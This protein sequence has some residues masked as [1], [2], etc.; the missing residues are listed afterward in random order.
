MENENFYKLALRCA[1]R[2]IASGDFLNFYKELY[3]EKFSAKME[4]ED[5]PNGSKVLEVSNLLASECVRL[6]S[7]EKSLIL[8]NYVVEMVFVNYNSDLVHAFLPQ[9]YYIT[10]SEMLIHFFAQSS[11]F[12]SKLSDKLVMDQLNKY[13]SAYVIPS[14]LNVDATTIGNDLVVAICKFLLLMM[15]F[16]SGNVVLPSDMS[17]DNLHALLSRLSK[18]NKL[19]HKKVQQQADAKLVFKNEK[20]AIF[21][22]ESTVQ[23]FVSSPSIT[24]PQFEP[25][26][27]TNAKT[28]A[29]R[30]A[31]VSGAKYQDVKL[32][33]YYKNIWLNNKIINWAPVNSDFLTRYAS[34]ATSAFQ[35]VTY[36][37]RSTDS[38]LQ[39]LIET[40]FTCFAQFVNNKQYHQINS[41][42]NLLERQWMIFICKHLPLLI[43]ENGSGNSH[44]VP[45]ALESIDDKVVKAIRTY[46]S[47]KDDM[48]GRNE[49]L[50]DDYPSNNLDIRHE[51]I[52]N[53]VSL[54]LQSPTL[55]NDYLR[56]DQMIDTRTLMA[57]DDLIVKNSQGVQEL[58]KDIKHFL[59]SSLDAL[60]PEVLL[61]DSNDNA[62][63]LQQ[64]FQN[65]ENIPPTK[66]RNISNLLVEI[67]QHALENLE[68]DRIAK[69]C[70]VLS[71]NFSHSLTSILS[72]SSPTKICEM[73]IKFVDVSWDKFVEP[74]CKELVES[75]Y[76]TMNFFLS[77][78]CSI[79]LLIVI[80]QT[81]DF[82]LVD[83]VLN[84]P[85]SST[86]NSFVISYL[87]KLPEI[88]DTFLLDPKNSSDQDM[89]ARSHQVVQNWLRDLFVNGS[90]SD[91]LLQSVDLKQLAVL[92]P[93]IFKQ[94]LLTLEVG[95]IEDVSNLV[96]GLEY[97]L[98][99][100]M[101][102]GLIKIVY[103]LEQ[104]LYSL[105]SE[106]LDENLLEKLL[107]LLNSIF[108]PQALNEDSKLF[109]SALLRLNAVRLLRVLR[110]FRSQS[111][112]SYGIYSSEPSGH[113]KLELL[114]E[115]LL[116]ALN[117][118]PT[119][120]LDPR[121]ITTENVYSQKQVG[122]GRFLI[123]NENPIN[124]I[125]T[126]QINSFWNLHS[127]TYYNLDYLKEVINLVSPRVFLQDV[128]MTLEYKL[129][130]YGVAGTRNKIAAVESE[131]VMDYLFYFLVLYDVRTQVDAVS[132]L[133]VMEGN[134]ESPLIK[135]ELQINT[136]EVA[137]KAEVSQDDDFDMLFGE[138][139]TTSTG[140]DKENQSTN[141]EPKITE[142][143]YS[144][145]AT[146]E[147]HSFGLIIHE[148]KQGCN[149]ALST[150]DISKE[151]CDKVT[152]YHEKYVYLLKTC[153]F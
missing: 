60:E 107:T 133:Q 18:V 59:A 82:S 146:L 147:R 88:P 9:L 10:N 109:H 140:I 69:I 126:N 118:S 22:M 43:L 19:L 149:E 3:N 105:K 137:P 73:L 11:A 129:D 63:G 74:R 57:S 151:V 121:V 67:L 6:L 95:A 122:Y 114:I 90:I 106:S 78:S 98:Q 24:S 144:S 75:E 116:S 52:K 123:L 134:S 4:N 64:I 68:F 32:V 80:W 47:E 135:E 150:G 12:F 93:F 45:Q 115:K 120:N 1:D 26:P 21:P 33:R 113:P 14:I 91:D 84:S 102:I 128:L 40:S 2:Q 41:N 5:T 37:P 29:S 16:I 17:R 81:Y 66:Q 71:F 99:P 28:P 152:K 132:L 42:F 112:S 110:Q 70:S 44:M 92:V 136:T 89:R 117:A 54:G 62:D 8:A 49:D 101:L 56:E 58:V 53:L 96:G 127:S 130:T 143:K 38:I 138:P 23:E 31:A 15:N 34:I 85:E 153:V 50:F 65:F 13:L 86:E 61:N 125:M 7:F 39:D 72:F 131:H 76:D 119:Y 51:F 20:N 94:V 100:F 83:V 46:Y 79:L 139:E 142:P 97:F 103:W 148:M 55:L 77:F 145:I 27:I 87:S 25:S 141:V 124:K 36:S 48:K 30:G 108:N 111:Q 104:Y 35:G